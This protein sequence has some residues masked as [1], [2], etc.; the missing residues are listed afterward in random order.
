V[1]AERDI[2]TIV[3]NVAAAVHTNDFIRVSSWDQAVVHWTELHGHTPLSESGLTPNQMLYL[4]STSADHKKHWI[5]NCDKQY[6]FAFGDIVVYPLEKG[7]EYKN[8]SL[9]NDVGFYIRL[10][11]RVP[12]VLP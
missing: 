11:T 4:G 5:V 10:G 3:Q 9:K 1:A 8:F 12:L 6:R 2:Q 7:I